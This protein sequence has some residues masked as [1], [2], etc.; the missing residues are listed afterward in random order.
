MVRSD[1]VNG[2]FKICQCLLFSE[3]KV[4]GTACRVSVV[5]A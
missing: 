2:L 4:L 5:Q 1:H 3:F